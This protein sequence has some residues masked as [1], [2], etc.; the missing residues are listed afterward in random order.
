VAVVPLDVGWN[1]V[2]SWAAI[3]DINKANEDNN[4]VLGGEHISVNTTGTLIQGKKRLI[5]TVGLEDVIIVDT[6]DALLVCA[7]DK[8]QDVK[9]VVNWLKDNGRE[10]LL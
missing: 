1:D 7:K 10:D 2:G 5:A 6:E 3:Y 8:V 9:Q 4:V